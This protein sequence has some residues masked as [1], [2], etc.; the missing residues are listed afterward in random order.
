MTQNEAEK[1]AAYLVRARDLA[2]DPLLGTQIDLRIYQVAS[3][4]VDSLPLREL[5]KE[6]ALRLRVT[7]LFPNEGWEPV[8]Q[9]LLSWGL[10]GKSKRPTHI[11]NQANSYYWGTANMGQ[12][13]AVQNPI[14]QASYISI[15]PVNRLV[16][17]VRHLVSSGKTDSAIPYLSKQLPLHVGK[18]LT[19]EGEE[20]KAHEFGD[21]S[22]LILSEPAF[23]KVLAESKPSVDARHLDRARYAAM[24]ELFDE[25]EQAANT[26]KSLLS[27]YPDHPVLRL[28]LIHSLA[29][30]H[31]S[32]ALDELVRLAEEEGEK[33][34]FVSAALQSIAQRPTE[35]F[36]DRLDL[37]DS[38]LRFLKSIDTSEYT[39]FR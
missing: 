14:S 23:K 39:G 11:A 17:E 33:I 25:S 20:Y 10:P 3:Q 4:F 26:Y 13:F 16:A 28:R 12:Q 32:R 37:S 31:P 34:Q 18:I 9:S 27:D 2:V 1:G 22:S 5:G 36:S 7:R 35:Q 8:G 30:I 29:G 24:C 6:A 19:L 15:P 38:F 21:L